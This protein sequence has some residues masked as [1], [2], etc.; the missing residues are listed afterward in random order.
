MRV[1]FG[2]AV[3]A[4]FLAGCLEDGADVKSSESDVGAVTEAVLTLGGK[5]APGTTG[6][7]FNGTGAQKIP[8]QLDLPDDYW[9]THTGNVEVS[10]RWH[11]VGGA[12]YRFDLLDSV[13]VSVGKA[14]GGSYAAVLLLPGLKAGTYVVA[15]TN[16]G[17]KAPFEGVVQVDAIAKADSVR[18]L[19]P[20]LAALAPDQ[21]SVSWITPLP[22]GAPGKACWPTEIVEKQ[23]L[24]CLRV[25]S[26]V[27]NAGEGAL[28]IHMS[29]IEGAKAAAGLGRYTQR[30]YSTDG[31][32]REEP[33][34]IGQFHPT[35]GHFHYNGLAQFTVY[36]YDVG[37]DLRGD[38]VAQSR[39]NGFCLIDMGLIRLGVPGTTYAHN[40]ETAC[41]VPHEA[42]KTWIVGL[43]PSWYDL[44]GS[45]LD[46]QS[47]NINGVPDGVYELVYSVNAEKTLK[48]SSLDDN[49][50]STVFQLTGDNVKVLKRIEDGKHLAPS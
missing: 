42:S 11:F 20:N 44:Y 41:L 14:R 25:S 32:F 47:V 28:E 8:F 45:F 50:A 34:G 38:K 36:K 3:A 5:T 30:I 37:K 33:V 46:D 9:T 31:K 13:G 15:V 29:Q 40:V 49:D 35:H 12:R 43:S 26:A 48:E 24:R 19:M 18:E 16:E 17:Q 23:H 1:T 4:L 2:L 10:L 7:L 21:L 22:N 27:G 6:L 39:K